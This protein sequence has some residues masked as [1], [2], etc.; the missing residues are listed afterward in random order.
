MQCCCSWDCWCSPLPAFCVAE[1]AR[2]EPLSVVKASLPP[3]ELAPVPQP[4]FTLCQSRSACAGG[5]HEAAKVHLGTRSSFAYWWHHRVSSIG[6]D[7]KNC[8]GWAFPPAGRYPLQPMR[9]SGRRSS[10]RCASSDGRRER[11]S[12]WRHAPLKAERSALRGARD[13]ARGLE[14]G[15]GGR[16]KLAIYPGAQGQD[17]DHSDRDARCQSSRRGQGSS[18]RWL[19]PAATSRASQISSRMLTQKHL[20]YCERSRLGSTALAWSTRRV[21]LAPHSPSSRPQPSE[22]RQADIAAIYRRAP[23]IVDKIVKGTPPGEIPVEQP[24]K[25]E[26]S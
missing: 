5:A 25:Y 12:L 20:G 17:F 9:A 14:G 11:T 2:A 22:L 3:C 4:C 6:S 19:D 24:T 13:G 15:C 16:L 26:S 1:I 10:H 8:S 18:L 7:G 23:A 21:T